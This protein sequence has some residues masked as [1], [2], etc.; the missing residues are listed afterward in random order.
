MSHCSFFQALVTPSH[1]WC[2]EP[3][4]SLW[5]VLG[6]LSWVNTFILKWIPK[7]GIANPR[8]ARVQSGEIFLD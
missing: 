6:W 5:L 3:Q 2:Y 7:S 8:Y 1:F 4:S